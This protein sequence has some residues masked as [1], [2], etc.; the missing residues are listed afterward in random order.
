MV[1]PR[2][3]NRVHTPPSQARPQRV[4][5]VAAIRHQ[6]IGPLTGASRLPRSPDGHCGE[7]VFEEGDFR[8]GRGLQGLL[9]A[10]YLRHRP[11]PSTLCP[12]PAWGADC[13]LPCLRGRCGHR[14][15]TPPNAVS[16][17]H[18]VWPESPTIAWAAPSS[19][20]TVGV[21]ASKGWDS[22]PAAAARAMGRWSPSSRG[23]PR[24]NDDLLRQDGHLGGG[25]WEGKDEG[26][27]RP[28]VLS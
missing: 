19:R 12:G 25:P 14:Q 27:S 10:A 20:S 2:W 7:R 13:G 8:L 23:G 16:P 21:A 26:E 5:I 4:A 15:C 1:S 9:P 18:G 17:R 6:A 3:K 28:S 22:H 24:H 11:K